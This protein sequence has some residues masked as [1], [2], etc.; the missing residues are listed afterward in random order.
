MSKKYLSI[1]TRAG[2]EKIASAIIAGEKIFFS[3][4]A[5]G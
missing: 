5:V 4:M 1:I 2:R 3:T